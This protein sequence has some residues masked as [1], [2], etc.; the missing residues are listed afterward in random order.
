MIWSIVKYELRGHLFHWSAL[1]MVGLMIFQG[2]WYTYGHFETFGSQDLMINAPAIFYLNLAGMGPTMLVIIALITGRI[3]FKD[4]EQKTGNWLFSLPIGKRPFFLGRFWAAYL[5]NGVIALGYVLG[6]LLLPVLGLDDANR[7]GPAPLGQ[8]LHGYVVLVLPN[9][10]LLVSLIFTLVVWFR[11]LVSGYFSTFFMTLLFLLMLSV[12]ESQEE[13]TIY[14]LLDPFGFVGTQAIILEMTN[15][16]KNTTYLPIEGPLLLNRIGW[17]LLGLVIFVLGYLRFD[18]KDFLMGKGKVAKTAA[19]PQDDPVLVQWP[20]AVTKSFGSATLIKKLWG[21]SKSEFLQIARPASFRVLLLII[22]LM[23]LIFNL[24]GNAA[25]H[26]GHTIPLS[27]TMTHF[28]FVFGGFIMLLLMVWAGELFFS[29]R[30]TNIWQ[31]TDALPVPLWI[32]KLAKLFAMVG[33]SAVVVATF[34]LVGMLSQLLQGAPDL[35]ELR[36]YAL[37]FLIYNWSFLTY[38]QQIAWVFFIAGLTQ[39]RFL[40]HIISVSF[41]VVLTVSFEYGLIEELRYGYSFTTGLEDYSELSAYRHFTE[42]ANW[43]FLMWLFLSILFVLLGIHFWNRGSGQSWAKK[44]RF[45]GRQLSGGGKAFAAAMLLGFILTRIHIIDQ[46]YTQGNFVSTAQREAD[47]ADYERRYQFLAEVPQ[48]KYRRVDLHFDFYPSQ[49]SAEYE[50][51]ITLLNPDSLR[52]IDSLYLDFPDFVAIQQLTLDQTAVRPSRVDEQYGMYVY[53]LPAPLSPGDSLLLHLVGKKQYRGFVQGVEDGQFDLV[54]DGSFGSIRAFFPVIGYHEEE[55]LRRNRKREE[56]GLDRIA[57][58]MADLEDAQALGA[59]SITPDAML[60]RGS[61]VI[62]TEAGEL[63]L[64]PGILTRTW[65]DER[66]VYRQYELR[67]PVPF[68]WCL[69][70]L[71]STP[72][73]F[74]DGVTEFSIWA[75]PRHPYNLDFYQ[76]A[77]SQAK[78][79]IENTLGACKAPQIRLVEISHYQDAF[80]TFPNGLAISEKE[81]WYVDTSRLKERAHLYHSVANLMLRWWLSERLQVANVQGADMLRLALPEALALLL[82]QQQLGSEAVEL[83]IEKKQ[84][85]Y[86]KNRYNEPNAEPPLLLADGADYLEPNKGAIALYRMIERVG[87]AVFVQ[88]TRAWLALSQDRLVTFKA[89][90]EYLLRD[91]SAEAQADLN[92]VFTRR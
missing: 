14:E 63:P 54:A 45:R 38:I 79:F 77:L 72:V 27:T 58:R 78:G 51:R 76:N 21:L 44:W 12:A 7:Y 65:R 36:V 59:L 70:S 9:L 88:K 10:F 56:Q 82:V 50:A 15:A 86:D 29:D 3:L 61:I 68:N 8:L 23:I 11:N 66:R 28:R 20:I 2:I 43:Y 18:F 47:A 39:N 57:A 34:I 24:S 87:P 40:T 83:I 32:S 91:L 5:I 85:Y 16:A 64:A 17:T 37:D 89:Y 55:T 25:Y 53:P 81:G 30:T 31:I 35:I 42:S 90:Y 62:G 1:M 13:T 60:V 22:G 84:D 49:R 67:E 41:F 92:A 73:T 80:Y 71:A 4:I 33:V 69:G 48:P 52:S 26:V 46:V 6:M 74:K 19:P 75:H